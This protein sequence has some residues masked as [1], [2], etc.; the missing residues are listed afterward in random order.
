MHSE[1]VEIIC[2]HVPAEH[3][4]RFTEPSQDVAIAPISRN[5]GKN[6]LSVAEMPKFWNR[7]RKLFQI[8]VFCF[9]VNPN[10]AIWIRERKP[11]QKQIMN[12]TEH[13]CVHADPDGQ[14]EHGQ[15]TKRRRFAKLPESKPNFV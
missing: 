15:A 7:K 3:L 9:A 6:G 11:A 8:T 2:G 5:V 12:Q 13:G 1:Q 10:D 4:H 14:R